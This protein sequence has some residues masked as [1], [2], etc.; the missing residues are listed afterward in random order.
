MI[1][2]NDVTKTYDGQTV[3]ER[4]S[5]EIAE[6]AKIAIMGPSG[7]GKTTLFR[8][9]AGLTF[10]DSGEIIGSDDKRFSAVFQ[11]DRMCENLSLYSN[12]KLTAG[13][14]VKRQD[15]HAAL[16]TLFLN[17]YESKSVSVLS[18]GM[19]RRASVVRAMLADFDI[20]VLDEPF[21]GLDFETKKTTAKFILDRLHDRTLIMIT[22]NPDDAALIGAD[23]IKLSEIQK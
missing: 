15:I 2:F 23:I 14:N 6:G 17:E 18:G 4:L 19:K 12:I 9:L 5:L 8:L 10:P 13:K 11:D 21:N 3:I 1:K 16:A 7:S 20:L 22:H